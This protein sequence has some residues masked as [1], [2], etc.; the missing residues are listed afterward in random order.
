MTTDMLMKYRSGSRIYNENDMPDTACTACTP[1]SEI[2]PSEKNTL[3]SAKAYSPIYR[4]K[5][6]A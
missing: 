6:S 2:P 4:T 3:T 5:S 1:Y